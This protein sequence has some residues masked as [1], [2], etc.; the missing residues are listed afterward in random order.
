MTRTR[1][2]VFVAG[3]VFIAIGGYGLLTQSPWS[4]T[5]NSTFTIFGITM[6]FAQVLIAFPLGVIPLGSVG[7]K[8][9]TPPS[10]GS[11]PAP[12]VSRT[13][14]GS[15]VALILGGLC[16]GIQGFISLSNPNGNLNL[17]LN[18]MELIEGILILCGLPG[19]HAKQAN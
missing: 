19:F 8:I 15:G 4:S 9:A 2:F 6:S 17:L 18:V 16:L 3:L 11:A 13:F 10:T 1:W 7:S 5:V 14:R 12:N